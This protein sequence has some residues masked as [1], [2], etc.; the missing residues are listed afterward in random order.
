MRVAQRW[1]LASLE[2]DVSAKTNFLATARSQRGFSL[3]QILIAVA[4]TSFVSM[5]LAQVIS[6]LTGLQ[7]R[8]RT[9]TELSDLVEDARRV[10]IRSDACYLSLMSSAQPLDKTEPTFPIELASI[11]DE[12]NKSLLAKGGSFANG[13]LTIESITAKLDPSTP[14]WLPSALVVLEITV[15]T[16]LN[17]ATFGVASM[18]KKFS[19]TVETGPNKELVNC[20]SADLNGRKDLEGIICTSMGGTLGPNGL[21]D[22]RKSTSMIQAACESMGLIAKGDHCE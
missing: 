18:K 11:V 12:N 21:C 8:A 13:G 17:G 15:Q 9:E 1:A 14:S 22:L 19:I 6:N 20:N 16:K 3:V 5:I 10:L 7:K 2:V 4:L